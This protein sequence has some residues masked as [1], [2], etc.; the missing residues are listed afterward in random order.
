M[1]PSVYLH[2][3]DNLMNKLLLKALPIIGMI[4]MASC[5]HSLNGD[6]I[7]IIK[8]NNGN[9]ISLTPKDIIKISL[10]ANTTT[11][12]QWAPE[13]YNHQILKLIK[14]SYEPDNIKLMGS[15]GTYTAYFKVLNTGKTSI[16]LNYIRPWEK[17]T[18]PAESFKINIEA[19]N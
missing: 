14:T 2:I 8:K 5:I 1:A 9:T 15:G 16:K 19:V 13:N 4:L 11:G 12:Y 18:K 17:D 3:K 7:D 10:K 6:T